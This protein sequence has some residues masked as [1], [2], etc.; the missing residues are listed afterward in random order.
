MA[1]K[2]KEVPDIQRYIWN[3]PESIKTGL[4][5]NRREYPLD[6]K[7][8]FLGTDSEGVPILVEAKNKAKKDHVYQVLAQKYRYMYAHIGS[9]FRNILA[10]YAADDET[11]TLAELANIEIIELGE[12][13]LNEITADYNQYASVFTK[14]QFDTF[15]YLYSK[16]NSITETARKM[17]LSRQR[18]SKIKQEIDG[19]IVEQFEA[20]G[21]FITIM[22]QAPEVFKEDL[23]KIAQVI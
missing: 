20:L 16:R 9:N 23:D 8:D 13:M 15:I 12:P 14:K 7:V 18:V 22:K 6:M 5:W 17:G 2:I 11:K 10:C 3:H 19:I 1:V 4:S 21:S